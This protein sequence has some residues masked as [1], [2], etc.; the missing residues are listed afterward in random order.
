MWRLPGLDLVFVKRGKKC[1]LVSL[2]LAVQV[3]VTSQDTNV[4]NVEAVHVGPGPG[5]GFRHPLGVQDICR[6]RAKGT[7][8]DTKLVVISHSGPCYAMQDAV[9]TFII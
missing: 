5:L 8:L 1:V 3:R 2:L 7:F 6:I 4:L 9:F